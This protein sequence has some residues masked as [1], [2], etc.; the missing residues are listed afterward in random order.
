MKSL[1]TVTKF[2]IICFINFK[3][4]RLFK[5]VECVE[6]FKTLNTEK[7]YPKNNTQKLSKPSKAG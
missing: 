4:L 6:A 7:L 1:I 2:K 3:V 5:V